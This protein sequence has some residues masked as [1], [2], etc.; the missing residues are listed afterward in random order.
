MSRVHILPVQA[1]SA[2]YNVLLG[3]D[4]LADLPQHLRAVFGERPRRYFVVTSPEIWALWSDAFLSG[5]APGAEPT[6]LLLP[7]GEH[8]KRL[9]ALERLAQQLASAGADRSSV[10]IAF[11]GGVIGDMT[12]FLAAIYMRGIDF[13]QVPTT[14]LAQV[15][16]SVGGKTGVNLAVGKN[17][18]GSF[19]HPRLVL[20]D[21]AVLRTLPPAELRAG[22]FE[23]L[24]AGLIY[25]SELFAF[26]EQ[27]TD[28]LLR[29][30]TAPL[31]HVIAESVRIKAHVVSQDERE[32]GLRMILNFGH[33]VGHAIESLTHYRGLLHGE[34]VG[35][36]MRVAVEASRGRGLPKLEADRILAAIDALSLPPLPRLTHRRLLNAAAGDKK[37]IAG[38]RHF[39]LL[40]RIGQARVVKDLS[41]D[42]LLPSLQHGLHLGR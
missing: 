18:I 8:H 35:W 31:T 42:E 22:L 27:H 40:E 37:R 33:T 24:K 5:F 26:I 34:A 41:D 3:D 7:A 28:A 23:S 32:A 4:L 17:L 39:V 13:V 12:G 20:A 10:L 29:Q 19:H 11:G 25:D 30:E 9:A 1:A 38:V 16:S 36:G 2:A 6:S 15:D 21:T 14:L